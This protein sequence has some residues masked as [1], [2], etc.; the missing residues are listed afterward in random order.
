ML[1]GGSARLTDVPPP[2]LAPI[3]QIGVFAGGLDADLFGLLS[4]QNP[5]AEP[6]RT[7]ARRLETDDATADSPAA[8]VA[9]DIAI[10]GRIGDLGQPREGIGRNDHLACAVLHNVEVVDDA[11]GGKMG[12]LLQK[13]V[14]RQRGQIDELAL[15][16]VRSEGCLRLGGP[17]RVESGRTGDDVDMLRVRIEPQGQFERAREFQFDGNADHIRRQLARLDFA[18][19]TARKM[20]GTPGKICWRYFRAKS[21]EVESPAR[22][23][24]TFRSANFCRNSSA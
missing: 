13:R 16:R 23:R 14:H 4:R 7:F 21:S 11:V 17:V 12:H 9:I 22:T 1:P 20:M 5:Q 8:D 18:L 24:S 2:E 19:S 6:G 3:N 15:A 10:D